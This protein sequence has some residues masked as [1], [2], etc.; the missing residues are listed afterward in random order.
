MLYEVITH[1]GLGGEEK[2]DRVEVRWSTGETTLFEQPFPANR[3]Y[4]LTREKRGSQ[5]ARER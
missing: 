2:I 3:D 4:V 1:F 5:D